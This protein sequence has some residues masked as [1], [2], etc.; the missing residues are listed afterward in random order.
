MQYHVPCKKMIIFNIVK[1]IVYLYSVKYLLA[2]QDSKHNWFLPT[3]QVHSPGIQVTDIPLTER[4]RLRDDHLSTSFRFFNL[5][6]GIE[7]NDRGPPF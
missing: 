1:I 5:P 2:I 4:Q 6:L 3:P 7:P